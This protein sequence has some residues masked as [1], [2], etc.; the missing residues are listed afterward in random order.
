MPKEILSHF[1]VFSLFLSVPI[2]PKSFESVILFNDQIH[3]DETLI[4]GTVVLER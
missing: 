4:F 2:H 1:I 3:D